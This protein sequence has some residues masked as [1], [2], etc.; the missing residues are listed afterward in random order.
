MRIKE[1]CKITNLTD[2]A[3]RFY[4]NNGIINPEYT[5]NYSGRKNYNFSDADVEMLKRVA[6]LRQFDFSVKDIGLL[7]DDSSQ[8][9][10]VLENHIA[11]MKESTKQSTAILDG[12]LNASVTNINTVDDLYLALSEAKE[13]EN[14]RENESFELDLKSKV[15]PYVD[16]LKSKL[17]KLILLAFLAVLAGTAIVCLIIYLCTEIFMNL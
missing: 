11:Q 3:V 4:I 2:K 6:V 17:P 14:I 16:K 1:V 5:E 15:M 8:L 9:N 10:D 12:L 7:I 13:I